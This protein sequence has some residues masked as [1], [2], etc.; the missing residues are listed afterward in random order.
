M[1]VRSRGMP[2]SQWRGLDD[3]LEP[4]ACV[5]RQN[6]IDFQ[7]VGMVFDTYLAKRTHAKYFKLI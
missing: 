7:E 6:G 2:A 1:A 4:F 5:N 3:R